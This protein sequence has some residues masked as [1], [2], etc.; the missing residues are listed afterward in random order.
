MSNKGLVF[1]IERYAIF[2]GEGIRTNVFLKGCGLKCLWCANPEGQKIERNL[3]YTKKRCIGCGYCVEVCDAR[4]ISFFDQVLR[5][6]R[7]R[8]TLCGRC[9]E[10]CYAGALQM[11]S[12]T[13]TVGEVMEVV[14][15][16]LEFYRHSINGG[17]TLSGGEPL[18]QSAFASEILR[19]T[20]RKR[21]H[22]TI[23]TCGFCAYE[24]YEKCA[25][26]L[27]FIF[28]D[29][30]HMD[31]ESHQKTTGSGNEL[32]LENLR[33]LQHLEIPMAVRIPLIPTIN[34]DKENLE[35][36][37]D[38]VKALP[39]VLWVEPLPYHKLG[40]Q[41]YEKIGWDYLIPD[42]I[43]PSREELFKLKE[44]FDRKSIEC[45]VG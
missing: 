7:E 19:E 40:V 32:I 20:K 17:V 15:K 14:L 38:L 6:D 1:N 4:C 26:Y 2:D 12:E 18:M 3:V 33:K 41:K 21:L 30:K 27:D 25:A 16:D 43:P 5:I 22:T 8:C 35:R 34:D 44:I 42:I 39:M 29:I 23:E 24:G 36:T 45:R 13:M 37:A 31:R 9:V 28:F 10:G 11:D